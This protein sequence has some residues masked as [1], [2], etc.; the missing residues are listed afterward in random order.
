M[1]VPGFPKFATDL[2]ATLLG[3]LKTQQFITDVPAL[4]ATNTVLGTADLAAITTET[5]AVSFGSEVL[6]IVSK[7]AATETDMAPSNKREFMSE[8]EALI[9]PATIE[10][11]T[12]PSGSSDTKG[13]AISVIAEPSAATKAAGLGRMD[14]LFVSGAV[15]ALIVAAVVAL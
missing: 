7:F 14:L 1:T 5:G 11:D 4:T 10:A 6:D 12:A 15:A 3:F 2:E 9:T 8:L 13:A